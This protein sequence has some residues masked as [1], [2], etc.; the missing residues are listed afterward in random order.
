MSE[1]SLSPAELDRLDLER[2]AS[3]ADEGGSAGAAHELQAEVFVLSP[4]PRKDLFTP[5]L[6]GAIIATSLVVVGEVLWKKSKGLAASS[7]SS[8]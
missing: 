7:M 5:V 4:A 1:L 6:M 8:Q 2:A 3:M